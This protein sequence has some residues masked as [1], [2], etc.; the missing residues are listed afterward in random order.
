MKF[1]GKYTQEFKSVLA[2]S[3]VS[4]LHTMSI[5]EPGWGKTEM[6]RQAAL[7]V[8]GQ[9]NGVVMVNLDPSTPPEVVRGAYD[10]AKLLNG[11]LSRI[12]VGTP[13]DPDA[14]IIILDEIW[15]ANDV[16]FDAL[17]H[18]T[19]QK[20]LDPRKHPVF[21]ASANFVG[22]SERSEALRDRFGLWVWLQGSLD[23]RGVAAGHLLNGNGVDESF[24]KGLP[25]WQECEEIKHTQPT[26]RSLDLVQGVIETLTVEAG[27][28]TN[29]RK[30]P[31]KVNPRRI[32]H[33][34]ELVHRMSV[35]LTGTN[36]YQSVPGGATQCLKY[37]YPATDIETSRE[38]AKV[39]ISIA[40]SV[41]ELIEKWRDVIYG[42]LE[43]ASNLD[44]TQRTLKIGNLGQKISEAEKELKSR[45]G[46]DPRVQEALTQFMSWFTKVV[47]GQK[48]E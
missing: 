42:E 39:A 37:A 5:S 46:S 31:F 2:A 9:E 19:S 22:K 41:G 43:R 44:L 33:W 23:A 13:Y 47:A 25:S 40:D 36:D 6:I 26:A 24:Q 10:P 38:W 27:K 32:V 28:T 16:V 15:R 18:A 1:V 14:H 35:Y 45:G 11:E 17:I 30:V 29:T 4:G 8:C 7:G 3:A 20:A 21:W 34:A 12:V 48:L